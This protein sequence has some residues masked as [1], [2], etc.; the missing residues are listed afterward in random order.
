MKKLFLITI[1][2]I[3]VKAFAQTNLPYHYKTPPQLKDGL[4]TAS[5]SDVAIDSNKIITLT[6]KILANT[7]INIH[8]VLIIRDNKLVYENYFPGKEDPYYGDTSIVSHHVDYIH[9]CR[10]VSKSVV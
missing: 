7:Y 3:S 8:S 4:P 1:L 10:S 9:E 2:L 6:K 5:L